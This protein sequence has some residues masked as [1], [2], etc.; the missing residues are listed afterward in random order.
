MSVLNAI[1]AIT[2]G[3]AGE[4]SARSPFINTVINVTSSIGNALLTSGVSPAVVC[5]AVSGAATLVTNCII[6][7]LNLTNA[8]IAVAADDNNAA[9]QVSDGIFDNLING[10]A[11]TSVARDVAECG[12]T[13]FVNSLRGEDVGCSGYSVP[14]ELAAAAIVA[15]G[16]S[17]EEVNAFI[18]I[19]DP[20]NDGCISSEEILNFTAE[21]QWTGSYTGPSR[22]EGID[23]PGVSLPAQQWRDNFISQG[24]PEEAVNILMSVIDRNADG[25]IDSFLEGGPM[26]GVINNFMNEYGDPATA[27]ATGC[28]TSSVPVSLLRVDM[29]ESGY[30]EVEADTFLTLIDSDGDGCIETQEFIDS[31]VRYNQWVEEYGGEEVTPGDIFEEF[32]E[33]AVSGDGGGGG[34]GGSFEMTSVDDNEFEITTGENNTFESLVGPNQ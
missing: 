5:P 25:C 11:D 12:G 7:G 31:V 19:M 2:E 20:N 15:T 10:G 34:D 21:G 6:T 24:Y 27:A 22:G 9:N 30:S 28:S 1:D 8:D 14:R 23:C 32:I 3:G 33:E 16:V 18:N 13:G 4:E 17:E 26:I 29:I